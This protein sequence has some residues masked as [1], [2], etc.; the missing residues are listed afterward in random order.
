M[1]GAE[2]K[3]NMTHTTDAREGKLWDVHCEENC[4]KLAEL[5]K[6]YNTLALWRNIYTSC[7]L[8]NGNAP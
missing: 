4:K 5:F 8:V 6:H 1:A 7:G 3:S 2:N